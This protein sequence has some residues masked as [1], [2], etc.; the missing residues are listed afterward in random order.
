MATPR[1]GRHPGFAEGHRHGEPGPL[2]YVDSVP[3]ALDL[4]VAKRGEIV[5]PIGAEIGGEIRDPE[6]P[7][8]DSTSNP[9]EIGVERLG[10][11]DQ[12]H[13]GPKVWAGGLWTS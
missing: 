5:Q 6:K 13:A 2:V 10:K 12:P 9:S 1:S 3:T 4:I 7:S 8:S 11:P